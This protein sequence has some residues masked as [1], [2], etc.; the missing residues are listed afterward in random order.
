MSEKTEKAVALIKE[1]VTAVPFTSIWKHYKGGTY[2]V[3]GSVLNTDTGTAMVTY[4]RM[5]GPDFDRVAEHPLIFARPVEQW[6]ADRFTFMGYATE[7][8]MRSLLSDD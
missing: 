3:I 8:Q 7:E 1:C 2:V 5:D 6:T 4:K